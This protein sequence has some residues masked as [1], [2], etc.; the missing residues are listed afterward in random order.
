MNIRLISAD[1][2]D[3]PVA[4]GGLSLYPINEPDTLP[5]GCWYAGRAEQF[6]YTLHPDAIKK[7]KGVQEWRLGTDGYNHPTLIPALTKPSETGDGTFEVIERVALIAKTGGD[8]AVE[9]HCIPYSF[10]ID[11]DWTA[12]LEFNIYFG[13]KYEPNGRPLLDKSGNV[14]P[15]FK[16]SHDLTCGIAKEHY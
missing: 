11:V 3:N 12:R 16:V 4:K 15:N 13:E 1:D 10:A 7:V 5:I 8:G 2:H 9:T 6:E 14:R